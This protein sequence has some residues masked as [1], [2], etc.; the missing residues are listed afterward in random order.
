VPL[1]ARV[2]ACLAL[3]A[4]LA[5]AAA[6]ATGTLCGTVRDAATSAP[7][8]DAGIFVFTTAGE[9]TGFEGVSDAAGAFCIPGIPA[10]TYDLQVRRD[11]YRTTNVRNVVVTEDVTGVEVDVL[12]AGV[13]LL[14]PHPNP[15]RDRVDF[16]LRLDSS[17]SLRLEVFD[18]RGRRL[19]GWFAETAT[20]G[21]RSVA[22]DFRG[23]AGRV[24]PAGGYV[25]RL[26]F[27]TASGVSTVSRT[28]TRVP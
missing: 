17:G 11:H 21:E 19:K 15:A 14:P 28:F 6:F 25:V 3:L 26:T 9:F 13:A 20:A 22:W 24:M 2:L 7:V 27:A 8:A 12:Q 4:T 1:A 10:G 16:R 18:A 5:P 23:A